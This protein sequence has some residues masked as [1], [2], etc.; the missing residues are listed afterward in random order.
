[1]DGVYKNKSLNQFNNTYG[2][3]STRVNTLWASLMN[4]IYDVN[5]E[6]V[7]PAEQFQRPANVVNASFCGISGDAPSTACSQAG[8]VRSDLFNRNVF[9]PSRIDDSLS[10]SSSVM[11][12]GKAY[13]ALDSTPSEFVTTSGSGINP[14]FAERILGRLG[15]DPT[16]LW[17]TGTSNVVSSAKFNADGS[18]PQAVNAAQSNNTL[19]WTKSA[20]NDVIGYRV[21]DITNGSRS[22]VTTIRDGSA[23]K[24]TITSGRT[25]IVVAVDIT[26]LESAQSNAISTVV[27]PPKEPEESPENN[28]PN[29]DDGAGSGGTDEGSTDG[30]TGE[31][32]SNGNGN[33]NGTGNNNG[34]GNGTGQAPPTDNTP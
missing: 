8:L 26:G 10:G 15:G 12:G 5:P 33:G 4:S 16:K 1:M 24:S 2:Q 6:L 23:L 17:P 32:N 28:K 30:S 14:Q 7:D 34:G 13:I 31:G 19:T 9:I 25:Y 22:L 11:I 21:Y 18:P 20:S 29:P 27:E 3:P